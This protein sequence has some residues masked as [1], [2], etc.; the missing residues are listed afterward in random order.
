MNKILTS[1]SAAALAAL[2]AIPA[3]AQAGLPPLSQNEHV[4]SRLISA[5]IADRIRNECSSLNARM[6]YAYGQARQLK[7]HAEGLGYSSAQ[8]DAFLDSRAERDRIYAAADRYLTQAGAARGDGESYCRVGRDEI[9]R[10]TY[11][12][13]FLIER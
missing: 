13:S 8:I 2:T 1:I 7:R 5:R 11:T 4:N 10:N 6:V 12:G 3:Q 9:A